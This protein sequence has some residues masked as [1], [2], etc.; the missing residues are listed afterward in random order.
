[1][2]SIFWK[3]KKKTVAGQCY[4]TLLDKRQFKKKRMDMVKKNV[5]LS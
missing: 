3:K 1:M 4:T 5:I 2:A